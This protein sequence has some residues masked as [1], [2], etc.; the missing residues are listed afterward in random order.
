MLLDDLQVCVLVVLW[1]LFECCT[2]VAGA[3]SVLPSSLVQHSGIVCDCYDIFCSSCIP[4]PI[5]SSCIIILCFIL[6]QLVV[7]D[8]NV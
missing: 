4:V 3:G 7:A 2:H 6:A 1:S 5:A 8:F